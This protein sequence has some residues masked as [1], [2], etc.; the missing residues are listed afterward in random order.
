GIQQR[1]P[2]PGPM[3]ACGYLTRVRLGVDATLATRLPLEVL[4]GIGDP[5]LVTVDAG[6]FEGLVEHAAGGSDEGFT[7]AVLVVAG[8]LADEH[9]LRVSRPLAKDGLRSELPE[10]AG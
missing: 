1:H 6:L 2:P 3:Q 5:D 8:L 4:D 9:D 10:I 7:G